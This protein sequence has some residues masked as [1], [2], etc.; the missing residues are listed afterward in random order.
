MGNKIFTRK[1]GKFFTGD[2]K[3]KLALK[4]AALLWAS[5]DPSDL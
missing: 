2:S 5:I 3:G 1:Q 4:S